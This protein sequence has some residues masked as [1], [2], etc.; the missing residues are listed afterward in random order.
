MLNRNSKTVNRHNFYFHP[1][2]TLYHQH[3]ELSTVKRSQIFSESPILFPSFFFP[4]I[5]SVPSI[6]KTVPITSYIHTNHIHLYSV[7]FN[8]YIIN[9]KLQE[10]VYE[11]HTT[12]LCHLGSKDKKNNTRKQ[13]VKQNDK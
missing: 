5:L 6:P 11:I 9:F 8:I 7:Q 1:I 13:H 4:R 2:N 10:H 12:L 3:P